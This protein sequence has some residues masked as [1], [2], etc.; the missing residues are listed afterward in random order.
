MK[1]AVIPAQ[2]LLLAGAL[3]LGA[4]SLAEDVTPPPGVGPVRSV[5]PS[6]PVVGATESAPAVPAQPPDPAAGAAIY[7]EKCEPCHGPSGMGD[8]PQAANLPNPPARLGD[9]QLA[10]A[11]LPAAWYARV[12]TGNLDRF[13]P[14]FQSLT[15]AQR[16]D[17]VAYSL[18]LSVEPESRAAAGQAYL[19][20]CAE[21][22]G[23][24]GQG[25][26]AGPALND[27][28]AMAGRSLQ[29]LYDAITNGAGEGMPAFESRLGEEERWA[30]AAAVRGLAFA[31]A[32]EA[33]PPAPTAVPPVEGTESAAAATIVATAESTAAPTLAALEAAPTTGAVRGTVVEGTAGAS[34]PD[35]LEVTLHAFDGQ[36]EVL[37]ETSQVDARG[38]FGFDDLEI[39]TGRLFVVTADVEGV[40]YGTEAAH[41]SDSGEA[42]ELTLLVYESTEDTQALRVDRMHVLVNF[43][44]EALVEMI[45]LWLV[46]NDGDR[47][48]VPPAGQGVLA[49]VLPDG[50]L[51]LTFEEGTDPERF[52]VTGNGFVDTLPI[53]PGTMSSQVVFS[54]VLPYDGELDFAQPVSVPVGAGIVIVPEGGPQL[55]GEGLQ[56]EGVR[57]MSG[58]SVRTFSFGPVESGGALRFR[59]S[60]RIRAADQA[61][62]T[63]SNVAIG[64]GVLG[65]ALIAAGLWW[66]RRPG[67]ARDRAA[68]PP[69]GEA[70]RQEL[71][72]QLAALDEAHAADQTADADYQAERAVL[73][74]RLVERMR[75]GRD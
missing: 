13:M 71:L 20:Q 3:L 45:Q 62:N 38:S 11:A 19:A 6:G 8:G 47:T 54:Y 10:R 1:S 58:T 25:A 48:V 9:A 30:L 60:G 75:D 68:E 64:I 52:S 5:V 69:A 7:P 21:C 72:R 44:T 32:A 37:T 26:E 33:A 24:G 12:T 73:K 4:C 29:S 65:V 66:Y 50:A 39:V 53:R 40:L 2:V 17:V 70:T 28:S 56:D 63:L 61:G 16:W 43:S 46:S 27:P 67:L 59:L 55:S 22:H 18:E 36:A 23:E 74:Q 42:S 51:N 14:G 49:V 41:L 34:L 35:G 57:D 15:D 31:G